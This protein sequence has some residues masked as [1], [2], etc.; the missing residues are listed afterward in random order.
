MKTTDPIEL[1]KH[2]S[3]L[4]VAVFRR[5]LPSSCLSTFA[6]WIVRFLLGWSAWE[7]THSAWWVGVVAGLMLAPCFLLSP[8]F[9]I[10]SDRIN[11]RNG[12]IVSVFLQALVACAGGMAHLLGW[13]SLPCLLFLA[14]LYGAVSS[15]HTPIRLA[16]IPLLVPREML[17]SAV[18]FSA[19]IFNTSRILAPAAAAWLIT[20]T[21]VANTF[22]TATLLL[23]A[24]LPFLVSVSGLREKRQR[25]P[26]SLFEQFKAGVQHV[27]H[28]SGIR[29][30][31]GYTLLNAFLGRTVLELLPALSGQLLSGGAATL[32]TLS[33]CAGV[34]SILGGIIM[35][36]QRSDERRML[37]LLTLC[38][39]VGSI[40]LISVV[41]LKGLVALCAVIMSVSLITTMVGTGTQILTQL[42]VADDYRGRVLSLWTV[43]AMGGPALG[44]LAMGSLADKLGFPSVLPGF[45]LVCVI[46][47]TM[48]YRRRDRLLSASPG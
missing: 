41:W 30:V 20:Q 46:G 35:S 27:R 21:S 45:S 13:Y 11:P 12:L 19:I 15:A 29:L 1:K 3:A 43:L 39:A 32:A 31:F 37:R 17:P 48:L 16:L 22:F 14:T 28:H 44:V 25:E 36:R 33:A 8:I 6:G 18:G 5:Y 42:L 47:V 7:L 24:A 23:A 2:Q 9:G 38:L 26:T 34:G 40:C 4:S 10:V